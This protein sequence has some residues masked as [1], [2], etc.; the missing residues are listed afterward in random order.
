MRC[1]R[2]RRAAASCSVL[3]AHAIVGAH[4]CVQLLRKYYKKPAGNRFGVKSSA[5]LAAEAHQPQETTKK[6]QKAHKKHG[7]LQ[8]TAA[9]YGAL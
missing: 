5:I 6:Q 4:F 1:G 3:T 7:E 9:C 2:L 8:Y